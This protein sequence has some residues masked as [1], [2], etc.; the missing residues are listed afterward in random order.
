MKVSNYE[1]LIARINEINIL[2][3]AMEKPEKKQSELKKLLVEVS[4]YK[5]NITN[6]FNALI[7]SKIPSK[8]NPKINELRL[9]INKMNELKDIFM[10]F[11]NYYYGYGFDK[12]VYYLNNPLTFEDY[13]ANL[14]LFIETFK[15]FRIELDLSKFNYSLDVYN[16]MKYFFDPSDDDNGD[17]LLK[18]AFDR[19]YW[20]NP[21]ILK[22]ISINV[23]NLIKEYE[24]TIKSYASKKYMENKIDENE[25][26]NKYNY[27]ISELHNYKCFDYYLIFND[28]KAKEYNINDFIVKEEEN[29]KFITSLIKENLYKDYSHEEK[30]EFYNNVMA[31]SNNLFE[32]K[33]FNEY[34]FLIDEVK[35]ILEAKVEKS[36]PLKEKEN[37]L[38]KLDKE[39]ISLN[40]K[41]TNLNNK[42]NSNHSDKLFKEIKE[43]EIKIDLNLNKIRE[44]YKDYDEVKFKSIVINVINDHSSLK[45]IFYLYQTNY[46]ELI[47]SLK[48]KYPAESIQ[49]LINR[50]DLFNKFVNNINNKLL[51]NINYL[52]SED[53]GRIISERYQLF[54]LNVNVDINDAS[55]NILEK[56]V[57]NTLMY[58]ALLTLKINIVGFKIVLENSTFE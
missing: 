32:Y 47:N 26:K 58:M 15:K 37:E 12:I 17:N 6:L 55:Y 8:E 52:N 24:N 21:N 31:L 16:Y 36:D 18:E 46:S 34:K 11:N 13:N 45:N 54:N 41:L 1:E 14:K 43:L 23:R 5:E 53:V 22:D 51:D 56:N 27:L 28:F 30:Q 49:N 20:E 48:K 4:T 44:L 10:A 39:R 42:Y 35:A 29:P 50:I 38:I 19:I 25:F 40:D 9:E 3:G 7:K 2:I 33:Y 57:K